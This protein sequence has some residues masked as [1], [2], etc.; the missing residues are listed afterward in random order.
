M[1]AEPE[2][3]NLFFGG[4]R[5]GSLKKKLFELLIFLSKAMRKIGEIF[6][7]EKGFLPVELIII[8]SK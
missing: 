5:S 7:T 2:Q 1:I 3:N 8:C 4:G 6:E